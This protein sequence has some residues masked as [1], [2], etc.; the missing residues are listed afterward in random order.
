[1]KWGEIYNLT[2]CSN[3]FDNVVIKS[4]WISQ[5]VVPAQSGVSSIPVKM[6]DGTT[7]VFNGYRVVHN[8]A[9]GPAKGGLR[10]HPQETVDSI[11]ALSMWM[12]W[13]CAVVDI[14]LGGAKGGI[15]CDP[16]NLSMGE[17]ERLCRGFIRQ[18][19]KNIGPVSDVPAPTL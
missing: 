10:F 5:P 15:V 2:K 6:D 9:R 18:M 13:K 19:A 3:E 14:P 4:I 17:Q 7:K 16:R 8:D 1:M 11:R 12:T